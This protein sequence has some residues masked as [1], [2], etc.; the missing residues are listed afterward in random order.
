MIKRKPPHERG[1]NI[2]KAG[3]PASGGRLCKEA[4]TDPEKQRHLALL[5]QLERGIKPP[6]GDDREA[7]LQLG[8]RL[9]RDRMMHT[10]ALH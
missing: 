6:P 4:L 9:E 7:I 2:A 5:W 10:S 8:D 3:R 1:S